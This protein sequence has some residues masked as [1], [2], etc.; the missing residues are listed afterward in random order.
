MDSQTT[1]RSDDLLGLTNS[2]RTVILRVIVYY[3]E[4]IQIKISQMKNLHRAESRRVPV[5]NF[6]VVLH[7][8]LLGLHSIG[9]I[10]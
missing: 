8:L 4:R 3:G 2:L 6:C 9:I 7:V 5:P 1:V 10:D